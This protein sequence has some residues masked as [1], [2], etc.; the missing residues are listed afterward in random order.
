MQQNPDARHLKP[1]TRFLSCLCGSKQ[2]V[3]ML[4]DSKAQTA[5]AHRIPINPSLM[6]QGTS[7][8]INVIDY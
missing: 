7:Y 5:L 8:S 6:R 3:N 1:D 2:T 4:P